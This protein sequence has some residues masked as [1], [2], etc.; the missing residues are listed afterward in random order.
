MDSRK[1]QFLQAV[2]GEDGARALSKAVERAEELDQAIFPRTILAWLEVVAPFGYDGNVPG[3]TVP[4]AFAKTQKGFAG[5]IAVNGEMHRFE[6]ATLA[7]VAGC[8]AVALGLDHERVSPL[9][10]NEQL[11]K[12]GKSID[13]LIK[14]QLVKTSWN[15]KQRRKYQFAPGASE[16][17]RSG[18]WNDPLKLSPEQVEARRVRYAQ[19][20]GLDP[21]RE[22]MS[23]G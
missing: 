3:V 2:V 8:V 10:K 23:R 20:I 19:S 12:L 5:S 6:D 13:L 17:T 7:H 11:A 16:P 18:P 9:A 4:F 15:V 14:S 22:Q 1:L 21:Y